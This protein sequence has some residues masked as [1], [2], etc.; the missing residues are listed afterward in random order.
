M[1]QAEPWASPTT[2]LLNGGTGCQD[3]RRQKEA[4]LCG[5]RRWRCKVPVTSRH[6]QLQSQSPLAPCGR[7]R[8]VPPPQHH[9]R[10]PVS[11]IRREKFVSRPC[12]FRLH[13]SPIKPPRETGAAAVL[14]ACLD[15]PDSGCSA[16]QRLPMEWVSISPVHTATAGKETIDP[17]QPPSRCT[18]GGR[19]APLPVTAGAAR[20]CFCVWGK[21]KAQTTRGK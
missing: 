3:R 5:G 7:Q 8:S 19:L 14:A 17:V 16:V 15:F 20:R 12:L 4:P 18:S 2:R 21:S 6:V 9:R 1:R 11:R 13:D 10:R